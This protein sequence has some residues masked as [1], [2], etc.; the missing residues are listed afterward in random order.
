M[1]VVRSGALDL[2]QIWCWVEFLVLLSLLP[3]SE[4]ERERSSTTPMNKTMVSCQDL[5]RSFGVGG[6]PLAGL[7][8][9]ERMQ[10]TTAGSASGLRCCN[11]SILLL[12][13]HPPPAGRGGEG[14]GCASL[15]GVGSGGCGCGDV[16]AASDWSDTSSTSLPSTT[17]AV[18]QLLLASGSSSSTEICRRS[19]VVQ[20]SILMAVGQPLPPRP[21]LSWRWVFFLQDRRSSGSKAVRSRSSI[22]SG[23]VPGGGVVGRLW[24][25]ASGGEGARRRPVLDCFSIFRFRVV[26]AI[27]KDQLAVLF[28]PMVL[29]VNCNPPTIC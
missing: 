17:K 25:C 1:P 14:R 16:D 13:V 24:M 28:S 19:D 15:P 21:L 29:F 23:S 3:W 8:G 9:E 6:I 27:S 4:L 20:L 5:W 7:G 12:A 26:C 18:G 11:L 22:P 2:G 10:A